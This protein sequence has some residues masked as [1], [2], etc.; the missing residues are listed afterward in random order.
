MFLSTEQHSR[1]FFRSGKDFAERR[2]T[3]SVRR[4]DVQRNSYG[5]FSKSILYIFVLLAV[6]SLAAAQNS[7]PDSDPFDISSTVEQ[8]EQLGIPTVSEVDALERK[9]RSLF[10]DGNCKEAVPILEEYAKESNWIAN[11]ISSGLDPYYGAS[12][13][14][15][16]AYPFNKLKPLIPYENLS[17]SY[18]QKRNIAIAMQGECLLELGEKNKAISYLVKALDL[19]RMD[20]D[21]W[22][23]RT[24]KNLYSV[25]EVE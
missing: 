20:N 2:A 16:K 12:Y 14:D 7:R 9:A 1:H 11:L 22:W 24:R 10:N 4:P 21:L 3:S 19:I 25:I 6:P 17:N 13:D 18:K 8:V 5:N 23:E 15:R